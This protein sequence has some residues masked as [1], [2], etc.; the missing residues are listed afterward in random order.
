MKTNRYFMIVI[1]ISFT[2]LCGCSKN[3]DISST[4]N[5]EP[6]IDVPS[7]VSTS[8][9]SSSM[10]DTASDKVSSESD[11]N[12]VNNSLSE[13]QHQYNLSYIYQDKYVS[14]LYW[15]IGKEYVVEA[16]V[17][18][19]FSQIKAIRLADIERIESSAFEDF[20][21][22]RVIDKT[23]SELS[24]MTD[25]ELAVEIVEMLSQQEQE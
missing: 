10:D 1:M 11:D 6:V 18:D 19:S 17:F 4:T 20:S 23:G 25:K 12:E 14:S 5:I 7:E 21:N 8:N 22:I 13:I 3:D 9:E 16:M 15:L 24:I 2:F